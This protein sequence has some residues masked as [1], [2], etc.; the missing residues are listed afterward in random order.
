MDLFLISAEVL[1]LVTAPAVFCE[2]WTSSMNRCYERALKRFELTE[3]STGGRLKRMPTSAS[4]TPLLTSW[5]AI[6]PAP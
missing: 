3:G 4:S 1:V 6:T 5:E 2:I